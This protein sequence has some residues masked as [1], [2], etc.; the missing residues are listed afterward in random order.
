MKLQ[1]L[2]HACFLLDDG[3]HKVLTDPFLTGAGRPEWAEKVDPDVIFVTH[4]H[5]DHV[6]DAA[7]IARR[8]GAPVSYTHLDVYK[9][10]GENAGD[11]KAAGGACPLHGGLSDS[12]DR[13]PVLS[14]PERRLCPAG[15]QYFRSQ[16]AAGTEL[17]ILP[18]GLRRT[19]RFAA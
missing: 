13:R 7:A 8:T 4:G 2:G 5:G 10:Q 1:F 3:V 9:R 11:G 14:M 16:T 17:R 15:G 18:K 19:A 12:G 6:G